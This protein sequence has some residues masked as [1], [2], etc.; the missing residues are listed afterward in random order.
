MPIRENSI[1]KGV[2]GGRKGMNAMMK[3]E[4]Q[5]EVIFSSFKPFGMFYSTH[6]ILITD[7]LAISPLCFCLF[8]RL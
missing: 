3:T 6:M 5:V 8:S 1:P 7:Y 4:S 2:G